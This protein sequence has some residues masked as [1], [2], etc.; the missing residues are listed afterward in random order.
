MASWRLPPHVD[1]RFA[2]MCK[3]CFYT[4]LA[5]QMDAEGKDGDAAMGWGSGNTPQICERPLQTSS[6][7]GTTGTSASPGVLPEAARLP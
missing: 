5:M 2:H 7:Y 3:V 4:S 6:R 1:L